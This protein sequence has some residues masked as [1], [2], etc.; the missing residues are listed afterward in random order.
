MA[1]RPLYVDT[2]VE[3]NAL[4]E[5]NQAYINNNAIS[6]IKSLIEARKNLKELKKEYFY[7]K[8]NDEV[9]EVEFNNYFESSNN[10]EEEIDY[11]KLCVDE[12][13]ESILL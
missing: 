4:A 1:K 3:F 2:P 13:F 5:L 10:A 11:Y 6:N 9:D 7:K 12:T 8:L